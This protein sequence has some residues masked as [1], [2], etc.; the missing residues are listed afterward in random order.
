[1]ELFPES[2]K[3]TEFEHS[4]AAPEYLDAIQKIIGLIKAEECEKVVL[5]RVKRV[6]LNEIRVKEALARLKFDNPNALIYLVHHP[7]AGTWFGATPETLVKKEKG[8]LSTMSLAGTKHET[9]KSDW[10]EKEKEEQLI[11][12]DFILDRLA[13]AGCTDI[14]TTGPNTIQAGQ[15][16]HLCSEINFKSENIQTVISSLHPTPAI[17]G[18]P[19]EKSRKVISELEDESRA[20]YC[21]YLGPISNKD[22]LHLF[23]NL[24]CAQILDDH[25]RLHVGGGITANSNPEDEWNETEHK[26]QTLLRVL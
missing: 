14:E 11:V 10:S 8:Q 9:N 16:N 18:S 26:A 6:D 13:K 22:D 19:Y 2:S 3:I 25:L 20:Y 7:D 24:R 4:P 17:C 5:S 21:G 15:L 23:V 1:M 12:T